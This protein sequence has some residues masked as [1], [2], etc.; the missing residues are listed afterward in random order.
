M[1]FYRELT[2]QTHESSSMTSSCIFL[3]RYS[4]VIFLFIKRVVHCS[5][6]ESL[7]WRDTIRKGLWTIVKSYL[8]IFQYDSMDW[9]SGNAT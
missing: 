6:A 9:P 3:S 5:S 8:F 4:R 1:S 7:L 2:V